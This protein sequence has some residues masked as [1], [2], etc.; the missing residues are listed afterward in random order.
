MIYPD[1]KTVL[2]LRNQSFKKRLKIK[3][4]MLLG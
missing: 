4:Q 3:D 1:E 2:T